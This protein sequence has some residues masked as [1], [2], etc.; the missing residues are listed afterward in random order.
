M[1]PNKWSSWYSTQACLLPTR[2]N[3]FTTTVHCLLTLLNFFE[4]CVTC[5]YPSFKLRSSPRIPQKLHPQMNSQLLPQRQLS[6]WQGAWQFNLLI[7]PDSRGIST[8]SSLWLVALKTIHSPVSYWAWTQVD[9]ISIPQ[10]QRSPL[11]L[12][13]STTKGRQDIHE[14]LMSQKIKRKTGFRGKGNSIK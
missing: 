2:T 13:L 3:F 14:K 6:C 5:S 9:S 12:F 4:V 8:N 1:S 10:W 7:S 11:L